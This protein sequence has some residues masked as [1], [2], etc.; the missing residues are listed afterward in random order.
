MKKNNGLYLNSKL[1]NIINI[2]NDF[3]FYPNEYFFFKWFDV[4]NKFLNIKNKI[5][6]VLIN[7]INILNINLKFKNINKSTNILSFNN[8]LV[9]NNNY[10]YILGE[11]IISPKVIWNESLINNIDYLYYF[12]HILIH[13]FLHILG[14]NHVNYIDY[15]KMKFLEYFLLNLVW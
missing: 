8:N 1:I 10:S 2:C 14:Y 13:G 9:F 12:S 15:K 6:I 7:E 3:F 5:N 4:L 11:I